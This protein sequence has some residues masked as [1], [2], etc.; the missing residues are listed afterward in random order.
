MQLPLIERAKEQNATFVMTRWNHASSG[1][2]S[3]CATAVDQAASTK[4]PQKTLA[5][6][7]Q[8]RFHF[9][10]TKCIGCKCCVV[11]CN[12]QNG[13]PADINWR[14]VGEIEGGWYPNTQRL[15][16]SMGCNHCLEPTCLTGCPVDAY[17][18][19][20]ITGVVIH[21]AETCIGCQYCTW[22]CSYGVPQ[23]NPER[24]VVGKCD[25]CHNRLAEGRE[26]AC[27]GAC[28]EEAI[29]I[30][31]VNIADW[32]RNYAVSANAPGLPTADD[33]LSTTRITL[34]ANLPPDT[35]KVDMNRV[36]PEHPHWPLVFMT[37]LTQLSVGAFASI[38]L[39]QVFGLQARLK[40]AA[41]VSLTLGGLA[42]GASTMHLGRPVFAYRAL[43]M[44]KRSWLS[45][46]VL[47]FGVFSQIAFVYAAVLW[48]GL[49]GSRVI[50]V[51][52]VLA[53]GAGVTAS[54]CIYL[55]HPRPAWH[56]K[57]TIAEFYLAGT[58]LGPL[59]AAAIG[60]GAKEWLLAAT[61]AAAGLQLLNLAIKFFWLVG[62]DTVE[63][64][65]SAR[66]LCTQLRSLLLVRTALLIVGGIILPL[67]SRSLAGLDAALALAFSG[68]ILGRYLF[69]VSVVPKNMAASYL[70]S[71]KAAA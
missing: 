64:K 71:H 17:S 65:A 8:Y 40:I 42:L 12:E 56:S 70:G 3:H 4:I 69:F 61:A 38:W 1:R 13:N 22:N 52:T 27:V 49:P 34:P 5:P 55:V 9:D 41:L 60:L 43:K 54:A 24:G 30:E 67:Q 35:R 51:L 28:P 11:A 2:A 37:V 31:I 18:K 16:L 53:G 62:S 46:E 21:N 23:Y 29:Q 10:M 66:L 26:P 48:F 15:H 6:G 36:R 20:P 59:L 68:E 7:E 47:L 45:R 39:L 25:M 50:G 19:D 63:L 33:S 14:R 57:H 44:W 58:I 32:K